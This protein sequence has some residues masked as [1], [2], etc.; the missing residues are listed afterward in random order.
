MPEHHWKPYLWLISAISLLVPGRFRRG[1]KQEWVAE[2]RHREAVL[3]R[4]Q[5]LDLK[6]RHELLKRSMGA[7]RD[8]LWLQPQR[9]EDEMFQDLRFGVRMLLK[10]P[11]FT[12][13][14]VITL[15][16][17]IG[18]NSAIFSV[19]NAVMLK[20]LPYEEA[21]RLVML[22][23][24][25]PQVPTRWVSYP[26]FLD[27]R[28]RN[29]VFEAMST[30]RGWALT[31]TGTGEPQRL[32]ARMVSAPYFSIMRVKPLV[33]RDFLPEEDQPGASPAT[34]LSY[35][36]WQKQFGGDE[37]IIGKS[38]TLDNRAYNVVG[39]MPPAFRQQDTPPLWVL[40]GQWTGQGNWMQRDVRVAGF[41]LARLKPG[42]TLAA[43]RAN[44]G[45]I[46]E[47]LIQQYPWNN[48]S[49]DI[50]VVSLYENV[51]GDARPMLLLLLCAVGFVLLIACANVAN[52]L[53]ARATTRHREFAV[54]AALGATRLRL[55]RQLL[56]ESV[57]LALLGGG[58]G[59][60]LAWW[61]VELFKG[62]N[63]SGIP[64]LDEL[65]LDY[66]VLGFTLLISLLTGIIFGLAPARQVSKQGL[67]E[68]LKEGSKTATD[69]RSGKMRGA[70]V[71]AEVAMALVLL[72]GA[73]LLIRSFSRLLDTNPGFDPKNVA[74]VNIVLPAT[75]YS[76]K[77]QL[78][79]FYQQLLERVSA[80]PGVEEAS[81]S[82]EVP[83]RETGWQNDIAIPGHP[84]IEPGGEINVDWGI[85]S[86]DY[87][88]VMKIPLLS[89]RVFNQQEIDNASP[90]VVIDERLA[91]EFWP[92]GDAV[93]QHLLYDSATPHEIIGV[94][95]NVKT[96][97]TGT[98][99]RIKIYTPLNRMGLNNATLAIRTNADLQGLAAAVTRE[100]RAID[101]DLP[102]SDFQ[103]VEHILDYDISPRRLSTV[104][105][106]V[107]AAVALILAAVGIYGV[108]SHS[109]T[110]RTHEIGVRMALGAQA[111][112]VLRMVVKQGLKL[113]LIGIAI[114]LTGAFAV[115]RVMASLLYGVSAT[116]PL[117]FIAVS[118]L[119]A[120]ITLLACYL[121]ARRATRVD[122]M[123]A[124]RYE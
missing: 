114:G 18:A 105:L 97:S 107:F 4:W 10:K 5:K 55:I 117:T 66:R 59:L 72:I 30:T 118:L 56:T 68:T 29:Q 28:E 54:R 1:W 89:G 7:L 21:D 16:L 33:G 52:L 37:H 84:Q 96:Y 81:V 36:F 80:L 122:P 34:I 76:E 88:N 67:N 100:I 75:R 78:G 95:R 123:I 57:L 119:L 69:S 24:H 87:F 46:K 22:S 39:V 35:G 42:V 15:A 111:A 20:P 49:H 45:A 32:N 27:W 98:V 85:V 60:A 6:A 93:G 70:L 9:W 103:T 115:T 112:D 116:D 40:I 94:V 64:R 31:L 25:H 44:M 43:A 104:L 23:E 38:I 113:A 63:P 3:R 71:I 102:V 53:L 65:S 51:V 12:A 8:A 58:L 41:V 62:S 120:L 14:A 109:V 92:G 48:A 61:G 124:L 110:Q 79:R 50:R 82:N 73:G 83:G 11:G 108:M 91:K 101:K 121:P 74:T 47:Q 99:S 26:N 13:L 19:V 2:L 86:A 106:S 90:V 77:S 17:G